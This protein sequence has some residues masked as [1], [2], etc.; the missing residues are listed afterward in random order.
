M[1]DALDLVIVINFV[2]AFVKSAICE[3]SV[4]LYFFGSYYLLYFDVYE[5]FGYMS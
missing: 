2:Y 1:G 4:V 5:I 3:I